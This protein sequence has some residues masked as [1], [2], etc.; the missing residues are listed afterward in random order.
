[1]ADHLKGTGAAAAASG[2]A[3]AAAGWDEE[4]EDRWPVPYAAMLVAVTSIGLWASIIGGVRW[5]VG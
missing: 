2:D 1:M 3:V 5:L 4:R